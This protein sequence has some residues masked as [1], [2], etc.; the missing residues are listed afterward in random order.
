MSTS[1]GEDF[2]REQARCRQLLKEYRE[3][4]TGAFGAAVIE[5]TLREADEAMASGDVVRILRAYQA[6]TECN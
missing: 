2:P 1:V 3:I 6:M 4:P 5:Q